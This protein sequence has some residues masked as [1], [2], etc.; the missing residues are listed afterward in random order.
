MSRLV[1]IDPATASGPVKELLDKTQAQLG[2]IP[3]LYRT[4]A[5]SPAA[6]DG[7]LSFRAALVRGVLSSQLREQLALLIA[8]ENHCEYCVSAHTFRGEKIGLSKTELTDNQ[9]AQS[10]DAKTTA[11][12]RFA[13]AI[14]NAKGDVTDAE[15]DAVRSAGWNDTEIAEIVAHVALNIFSNY[16]NYVARPELD[17]LRVDVLPAYSRAVA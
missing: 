10:G 2:R 6:L 3:N 5:N 16:F 14:M 13:R 9:Q 15:L 8:A 12:L 17:F 1:T 7:Y 4:M 11:A